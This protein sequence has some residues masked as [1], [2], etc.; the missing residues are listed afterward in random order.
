M[1][2]NNGSNN[3][4]NRNGASSSLEGLS[5]MAFEIAKRRQAAAVEVTEM[6]EEQY[7][8]WFG[9]HAATLL[10]A[11]AWLTGTSLYRSLDMTTDLEPGSAVLS[12]QTDEEGLKL[13]KVFM[14]LVDK[15][16]IKLKPN[17]YAEDIPPEQ[18]PKK[19]ILDVQRQFQVEYNRIMKKYEFDFLEGAKTGAVACARLVRLHCEN[20]KDVEAAIAASTISM[21]FVEGAKTVPAPLKD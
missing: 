2:G 17:E 14:L 9:S 7:E 20:R 21:G 11:A 5:E 19:Q 6:L 3:N 16:G 12:D 4:G 18:E 10:R 1:A 8:S 13:M 15:S